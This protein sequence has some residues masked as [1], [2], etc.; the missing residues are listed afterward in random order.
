[1]KLGELIFSPIEVDDQRVSR[2]ISLRA[3][4][5]RIAD[6]VFVAEIN[7]DLADT[8]SFCEEYEISLDI[9]TNCLIIEARRAD[10]IW[11]S[12]CL[13]L[14][15]DMADVNGVIRKVLGARKTSFAPKDIAL[16]LTGMEYG[17]ITPIGLP[18]DWAIYIDEAVM[19]HETV[20]VGGGLRGSKIAIN[21]SALAKLPNVQI[22]DIKRV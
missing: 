5:S 4:E 10:K 2:N 20:V 8:V 11:Y 12:A 18:A 6:D 3:Y 19:N 13:I 21:T 22:L 7:P 16:Q 15:S 17:G 9:S 1:M 14:A